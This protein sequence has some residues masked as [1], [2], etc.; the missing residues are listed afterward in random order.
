[1][2]A[3]TPQT[4]RGFVMLAAD[5]LRKFTKIPTLH[6]DQGFPKSG[7]TS[8]CF[9][10]KTEGK[11]KSLYFSFRRFR[12]FPCI[13]TSKLGNDSKL[14]NQKKRKS[15]KQSPL[16]GNNCFLTGMRAI[17]SLLEPHPDWAL[18]H[19]PRR[20]TQWLTLCWC[21][22]GTWGSLTPTARSA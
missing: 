5:V 1:M 18:K 21:F 20:Q 8:F 22:T 10:L 15:W 9:T 17:V 13:V 19:A 7:P 12:S 4:Q 6:S 2:R 11:K 3:Q 14:S 16:G